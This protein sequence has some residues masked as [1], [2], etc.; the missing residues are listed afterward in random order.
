[1]ILAMNHPSH[2]H[3]SILDSDDLICIF[4]PLQE[5]FLLSYESFNFGKNIVEINIKSNF[6]QMLFNDYEVQF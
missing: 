6:P 1:M 2:H 5:K 4:R 3:H